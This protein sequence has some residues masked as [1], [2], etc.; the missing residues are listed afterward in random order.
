MVP[1]LR[2]LTTIS[3]LV[4]KTVQF[5]WLFQFRE[6]NY[7]RIAVAVFQLCSSVATISFILC[8]LERQWQKLSPMTLSF[9]IALYTVSRSI[10][11]DNLFCQDNEI[12]KK[13]QRIKEKSWWRSGKKNQTHWFLCDTR[14]MM[15]INYLVKCSNQ[16][17][18]N[19][20][21]TAEFPFFVFCDKLLEILFKVKSFLFVIH[22]I[23]TK[24]ESLS[25]KFQSYFKSINWSQNKRYMKLFLG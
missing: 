20:S 15:I 6:E 19:F 23:Q 12:R 17:E 25:L 2:S 13:I 24:T 21:F 11:P 5:R 16:L 14:S 3:L 4:R 22:L 10:Y 18:G 8:S 9:K 7:N 1:S